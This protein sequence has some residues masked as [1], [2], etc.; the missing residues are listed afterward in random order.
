MLSRK[1]ASDA[2]EDEEKMSM[3]KDPMFDHLP[4]ANIAEKY[5]IINTKLYVHEIKR[6]H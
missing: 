2:R 1:Q 3:M 4:R 6:L 5:I